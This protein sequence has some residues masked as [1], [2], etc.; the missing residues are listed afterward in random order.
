MGMIWYIAYFFFSSVFSSSFGSGPGV[1]NLNVSGLS[2]RPRRQLRIKTEIPSPKDSHGV[3]VSKLRKATVNSVHPCAY[4]ASSLMVQPRPVPSPHHNELPYTQS[5][6]NLSAT[7]ANVNS[8]DPSW[9]HT[10]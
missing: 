4:L 9:L 6:G 7:D 10:P 5:K 2:I 8:T 3:E 1:G